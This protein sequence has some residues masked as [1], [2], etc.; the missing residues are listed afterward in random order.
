MYRHSYFVL[1]ALDL[2]YSRYFYYLVQ[3][4]LCLGSLES[5]LGTITTGWWFWIVTCYAASGLCWCSEC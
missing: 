2:Y 1:L 3:L 5:K 4:L